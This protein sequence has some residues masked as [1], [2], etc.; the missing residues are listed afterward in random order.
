MVTGQFPDPYTLRRFPAATLDDSVEL[1][2]SLLQNLER[3]A[4]SNTGLTARGLAPRLLTTA[5]T[6]S[7]LPSLFSGH[8]RSFFLFMK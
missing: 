4:I 3:D 2:E 1:H 6:C 7:L 5:L 8:T